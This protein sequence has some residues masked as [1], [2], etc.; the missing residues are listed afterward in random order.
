M[1]DKLVNL[2]YK[3][4]AKLKKDAETMAAIRGASLSEYVRNLIYQ[5]C[6]KNADKI[7]EYRKMLEKMNDDY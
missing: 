6:K 4:S 7:A 2:N 3:I 1:A 5:D